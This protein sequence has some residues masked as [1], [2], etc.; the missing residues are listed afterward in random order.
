MSGVT[1]APGRFQR[2]VQT[3][4]ATTNLVANPSFETDATGWSAYGDAAGTRTRVDAVAFAGN[5][6]YELAKTGGAD[7]ARW[8]IQR[9]ITGL[10][11]DTTYAFSAWV[12][13]TAMAG[14]TNQ[15]VVMYTDGSAFG[16]A[17]QTLATTSGVTDGW[18]RLTGTRTTDGDGGNAVLY[19]WIDRADTGTA[20]VDAVQVEEKTY[21]TPYCDGTLGAGHAWTG[22]AHASTSTRSAAVLTYSGERFVNRAAGT[23]MA[24]VRA[25]SNSVNQMVFSTGAGFWLRA[26]SG[27]GWDFAFNGTTAAAAGSYAAGTWQHVALTW[28]GTTVALYVDGVGVRTQSNGALVSSIATF[29]IGRY[30]VTPNQWWTGQIDNFVVLGRAL[31]EAE[32]R[33]VYESDAPVFAVTSSFGFRATPR[34]T[35]WADEEGLW[36]QDHGGGA[37]LGLFAG[38]GTKSWGAIL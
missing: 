15:R 23:V 32:V 20:Y 10:A 4:E 9:T 8:G 25:E 26:T 31:P 28:N 37:A 18:V 2:A 1:F 14:G 6:S 5:W 11:A 33:V 24:W 22:T 16:N 30:R 36:A 27:G 29:D 7:T 19:F 35:V 17:G 38:E 12:N 21:A 13:V 34:Q 3:P